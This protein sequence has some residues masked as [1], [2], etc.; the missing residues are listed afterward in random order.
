MCLCRSGSL[1]SQ[2]G[3]CWTK[4]ALLGFCLHGRP[5]I[6]C[7]GQCTRTHARFLTHP[8]RPHCNSYGAVGPFNAAI[9]PLSL[10]FLVVSVSW[11]ENYGCRKSGVTASISTACGDILRDHRMLMVCVCCALSR[12]SRPR[13]L[14]RFSIRI[15]SLSCPFAHGMDLLL[16]LSLVRPGRPLSCV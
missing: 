1:D 8:S 15:I 11:R 14:F 12:S 3:V 7:P 6:R 4:I 5:V 9:L 10:C 16:S 2:N 13:L